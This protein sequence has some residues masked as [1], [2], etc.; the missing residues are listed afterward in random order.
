VLKLA[1]HGFAP[2][3]DLSCPAGLAMQNS[4]VVIDLWQCRL[5]E[6]SSNRCQRIVN[7]ISRSEISVCDEDT[8]PFF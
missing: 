6:H 3:S 4:T 8:V 7:D 5:V 2:L 1:I